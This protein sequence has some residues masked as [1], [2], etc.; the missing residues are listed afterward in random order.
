LCARNVTTDLHVVLDGTANGIYRVRNVRRVTT[1]DD[2]KRVDVR[3]RALILRIAHTIM[4]VIVSTNHGGKGKASRY[5]ESRYNYKFSELHIFSF[6]FSK[7]DGKVDGFPE[8]QVRQGFLFLLS[9]LIGDHLLH[10]PSQQK[11]AMRKISVQFPAFP[12]GSSYSRTDA[13]RR[14]EKNGPV[15]FVLWDL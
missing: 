6:L 1:A 9:S 4:I 13:S 5:N 15:F 12:Y 11:Q 10:L 8:S 7:I 14:Q 2:D 3:P